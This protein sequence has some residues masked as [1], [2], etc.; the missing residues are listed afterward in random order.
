MRSSKRV[1]FRFVLE[2]HKNNM[3]AY[4]ET[5]REALLSCAVVLQD[6]AADKKAFRAGAVVV[7]TYCSPRHA[8]TVF[9]R[10]V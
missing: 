10:K 3:D 8:A 1:G 9:C 4:V 7:K 6:F 5:L 2:Y